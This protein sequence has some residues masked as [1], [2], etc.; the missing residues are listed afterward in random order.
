MNALLEANR[1]E[2]SAVQRGSRVEEF[3]KTDSRSDWKY[4]DYIV[5]EGRAAA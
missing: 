2:E 4:L 1:E 5:K 3:S